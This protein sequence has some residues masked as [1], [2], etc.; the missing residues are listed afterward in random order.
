M[1]LHEKTKGNMK[2]IGQ[3][4]FTLFSITFGAEPLFSQEY[5]TS[6][7]VHCPFT[8]KLV[9]INGKY[10]AYYE[11]H[12]TNFSEDTIELKGFEIR[13]SA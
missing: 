7:Y 11:L 10:T 8:T 3:L 13:K 9:K 4:L 12:L 5:K 2:N 6:L 1:H